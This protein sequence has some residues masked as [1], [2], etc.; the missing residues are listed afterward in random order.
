MGR[1]PKKEDVCICTADSLCCT[2]ETDNIVKHHTPIKT[3]TKKINH[4]N[5][6]L[7]SLNRNMVTPE[8]KV[9]I[10]QKHLNIEAIYTTKYSSWWI[11]KNIRNSKKDKGLMKFSFLMAKQKRYDD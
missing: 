3:Q 5:S 2:V 4:F 10:F 7:H 8:Y 9:T 6:F 11:W 1:K